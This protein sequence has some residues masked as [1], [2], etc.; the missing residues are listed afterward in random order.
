MNYNVTC[1]IDARLAAF[2]AVHLGALSKSI[3]EQI[4]EAKKLA[5][6]LTDGIEL[7]NVNDEIQNLFGKMQS[8]MN[9][10]V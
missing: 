5:E 7:P 2:N 4:E 6:F 3:D 10:K 8:I 9:P 1:V